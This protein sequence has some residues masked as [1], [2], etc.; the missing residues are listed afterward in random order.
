MTAFDLDAI[1]SRLEMLD[2]LQQRHAAVPNQ[3]ARALT[4][5]RTI[6]RHIATVDAPALLAAL[7]DSARDASIMAQAIANHTAAA[8]DEW[9]EGV[10]ATLTWLR[11]QL[12]Q[13]PAF[14][15]YIAELLNEA[16]AALI[17]PSDPS[18][19]GSVTNPRP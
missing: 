12:E 2:L 18:D 4:D 15:W 19:N 10:R 6:E 3:L 11:A 9:D 14:A 16:E 17:P 7:D 13:R 1:R 8:G 5:P